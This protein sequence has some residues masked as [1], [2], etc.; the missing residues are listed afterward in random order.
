[1]TAAV[2]PAL[3]VVAAN[4]ASVA[5]F[6]V[7][8]RTAMLRC[9]VSLLA[10]IGGALVMGPALS[11]GLLWSADRARGHA[12]PLRCASIAMGII[13][14]TWF[15]GLIAAA[16]VAAGLGPE[17]GEVVWLVSATVLAWHLLKRRA[18]VGLAI[19]RRWI[20]AFSWRSTLCF[21]VLFAMT[22]VG[23]SM[24]ARSMLGAAT[25]IVIASP[26]PRELPLPPEP[27]W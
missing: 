24:T 13:W 17:L 25:E 26:S 19:R 11:L 1:M 4:I 14:P 15:L 3:A 8:A 7:D 16:P 23:P 2:W 21:G 18:T 5:L 10:V 12:E 22:A 20:H 6:A 27:N 9:A